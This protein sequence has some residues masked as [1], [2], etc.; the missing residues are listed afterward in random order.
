MS[1]WSSRAGASGWSLRHSADGP[2][3]A[4]PKARA[5]IDAFMPFASLAV[6]IFPDFVKRPYAGTTFASSRR[7]GIPSPESG[8]RS[9][10]LLLDPQQL[11]VFRQSF[12]AG[13]GADL[14][15]PRPRRH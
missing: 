13:H 1:D 9:A 11:V 15:L 10:H 8:R 14:D 5:R 2:V 3:A 12:A 4:K 7:R 6:A